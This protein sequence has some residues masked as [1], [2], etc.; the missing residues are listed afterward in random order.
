VPT[1]QGLIFFAYKLP[2]GVHSGT[3]SMRRAY[4]EL[5]TFPGTILHNDMP[6]TIFARLVFERR[7]YMGYLGVNDTV[8]CYQLNILLQE[9]G[10]TIADIGDIDLSLLYSF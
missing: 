10:R 6:T 8:F 4:G 5:G 1:A 2:I 7:A 9:H 3:P